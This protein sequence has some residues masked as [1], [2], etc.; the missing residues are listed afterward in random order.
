M[1]SFLQGYGLGNDYMEMLEEIQG[2]APAPY[3]TTPS[4]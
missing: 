4:S 2:F 1:F 3:T